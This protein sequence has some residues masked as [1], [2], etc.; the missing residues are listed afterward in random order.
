[1]TGMPGPDKV[2]LRAAL[3]LQRFD[4]APGVVVRPLTA[5]DADALTDAFAGDP[6]LNWTRTSWTR[7]NVEKVLAMRLE[8]YDAYGFG[9]YAVEWHGRTVGWAGLQYERPGDPDD[10]GEV[11]VAS[12]LARDAWR[13]GITTAVLS[14][15][16]D[17]VFAA[18]VPAVSASTRPE[19]PAGQA[20]VRRLGFVEIGEHVHWNHHAQVW[21]LTRERHDQLT[22]ER[23]AGG[24]PRG[25]RPGAVGRGAGRDA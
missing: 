18:G 15:A 8:H 22:A 14:W 2:V 17:R 24:A 21:S 13:H 23:L 10:P 6:E 7:D 5:D 9:L 16:L 12:Y 20:A 11:E 3:P 19:N 25:P 1:M 4:V